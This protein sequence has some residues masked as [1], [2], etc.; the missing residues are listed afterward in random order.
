MAPSGSMSRVARATRDSSLGQPRNGQFRFAI[1]TTMPVVPNVPTCP[2]PQWRAEVVDV[3]FGDATV[4]L[5]EDGVLVAQVI[6]PLQ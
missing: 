2:N 1:M 4:S 6:V 5:F 3:E